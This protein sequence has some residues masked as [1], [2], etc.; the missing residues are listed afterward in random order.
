MDLFER[1]EVLAP[2]PALNGYGRDYRCT[3]IDGYCT[4]TIKGVLLRLAFSSSVKR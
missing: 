1:G 2:A 4:L 3:R